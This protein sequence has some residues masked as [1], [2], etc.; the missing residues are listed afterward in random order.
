M[1]LFNLFAENLREKMRT[2]IN[3]KSMG[4]VE[5]IRMR[6]G[7]PVIIKFNKCEFVTDYLVKQKDLRDTLELAANHS[8]YAFAEEIKGGYITVEGGHRIGICGKV[9]YE[10]DTITTIKYISSL[11]IRVAHQILGCADMV[12]ND[13]CCGSVNSTLVIS[14]PGL[15]KTTLIRD[16]IRQISNKGYTVGVVDE[17]SEIASSYQG[18]AQNDIGIRTD[19]LDACP[20]AKGMLMMLRSMSPDVLVVDEIGGVE[21]VEALGHVINCGCS[22]IASVHGESVEGIMKKIALNELF[23][24]NYFSRYI[25]IRCDK[26]KGRQYTVYDN[27]GMAIRSISL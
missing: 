18:M 27:R 2:Y 23:I 13:I 20:K 17:R 9:V 10:D 4:V 15:G 22:V 6:A 16:M 3:D 11:N 21:D 19:I 12:I 1:V 24:H 8:V 7:Q 14:P 25:V 26:N 5:E